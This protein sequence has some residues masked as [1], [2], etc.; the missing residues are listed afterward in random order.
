MDWEKAK[1][2]I[3]TLFLILNIF[4]FY[5]LVQEKWSPAV[6]KEQISSAENILKDKGI[7][8]NTKIPTIS[9]NFPKLTFQGIPEF[10]LKKVTS[11]LLGT[12]KY[13]NSDSNLLINGD[14]QISIENKYTFLYTNKSPQGDI[15]LDN[16]KEIEKYLM[17]F[18]SEAGFSTDGLVLDSL[19]RQ[20]DSVTV[21]YV[22]K[23]GDYKL[24]DNS[25]EAVVTKSGISQLKCCLQTPS[26][27]NNDESIMPAY[28][29]LL[30]NMEQLNG[31]VI[32][33][34][35]LGYTISESNDGMTGYTERLYWRVEIMDG[36]P[37][38][39]DAVT[40]EPKKE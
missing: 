11:K 21:T 36:K 32:S 6:S 25:I 12:D 7:K 3:I 4:L 18:L 10:D 14:K 9:G 31:V 34:I 8:L 27:K 24:F 20:P 5:N 37:L 30:K 13:A 40:G 2:I 29:V 35:D 26:K 28:K 22:Q 38:D 16:N 19:D 33:S 15:S 17:K 23:K 1:N 39:Y